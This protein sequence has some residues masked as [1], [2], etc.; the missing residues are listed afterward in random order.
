MFRIL[1]LIASNMAK[2]RATVPLPNSVP[3]PSEFRGAVLLDTAKC[4]ACGMCSYVCVSDAIV[5][6][7]EE[8]AFT[9]EYEPGRCTFCA[10]CVERCP[11]GALSMQETPLPSYETFGDLSVRQVVPFKP[12]LDCGAPVRPATETLIGTAFGHLKETTRELLRTCER[13]RRKRLQREFFLTAY[14]EEKTR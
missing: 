11:G 3:V 9:W 10:R 5:G 14:G 2:E 13:C 1:S 8:K 4:L 7:N 6:T 12:C